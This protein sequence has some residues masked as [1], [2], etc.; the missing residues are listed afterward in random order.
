MAGKAAT[1]MQKSEALWERHR[2]L[3][4]SLDEVKMPSLYR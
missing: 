1:E 3:G 4:Q 2:N